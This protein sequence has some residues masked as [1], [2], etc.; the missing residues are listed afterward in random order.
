M[1]PEFASLTQRVNDGD[2]TLTDAECL[3]YHAQQTSL[4]IGF[5]HLTWLHQNEI[6]DEEAFRGDMFALRGFLSQPGTRASWEIT[7]AIST[8]SFCDQ[9]EK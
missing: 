8:P 4:L 3:R 6:M 7:K 9:V 2:E 1:N 5:D